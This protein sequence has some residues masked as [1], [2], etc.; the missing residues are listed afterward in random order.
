[1]S[2]LRSCC[3]H[4]PKIAKTIIFKK[5]VEIKVLEEVNVMWNNDVPM[6][7]T[8]YSKKTIERRNPQFA[9]K[10]ISKITYGFK[11]IRML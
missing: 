3:C 2:P 7:N 11:R 8:W 1:M 4:C 10:F 9:A 5:V 6:L